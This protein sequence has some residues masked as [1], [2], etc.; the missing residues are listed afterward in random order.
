MLSFILFALL[1]IIPLSAIMG[2]LNAL[3]S[4]RYR[5]LS[6]D[7]WLG[8]VKEMTGVYAALFLVALIIF[9]AAKAILTPHEPPEWP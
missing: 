3:A 8:D 5:L 1:W 9:V 4:H 7:W 2:F 6:R